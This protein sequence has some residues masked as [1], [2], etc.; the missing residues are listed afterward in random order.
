M[1]I[2]T[3]ASATLVLNLLINSLIIKLSFFI[4][5][6]TLSAIYLPCIL[7]HNKKKRKKKLYNI[8]YVIQLYFMQ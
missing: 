3:N 6:T 2:E 5:N 4:Q 8:L 1:H 7:S